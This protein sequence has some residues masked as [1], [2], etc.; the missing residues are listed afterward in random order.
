MNINEYQR[1][2]LEF[3]KETGTTCTIAYVGCLY[4]EDWDKTNKHDLYY[5]TLKNNRGEYTYKYWDSLYHTEI[6]HMTAEEYQRK[7]RSTCCD[8]YQARRQLKEAKLHAVIT[9]YDVLACLTTWEGGTFEDFCDE[10]GYDN[11]SISAYK[12]YMAVCKERDGLRKIYT[13]E[14]LEMLSEIQ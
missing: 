11:D 4:N 13:Y 7:N 8:I 6:H 10:F 3:L 5:V 1:Q 2:A 14:Q 9:E 12:T